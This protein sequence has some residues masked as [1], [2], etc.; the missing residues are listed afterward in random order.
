MKKLVGNTLLAATTAGAL[1]M[2]ACSAETQP[3]RAALTTQALEKAYDSCTVKE[4]TN[5][6]QTR[7][8]SGF[9]LQGIVDVTVDAPRSAAVAADHNI[10]IFYSEP[11]DELAKIPGTGGSIAWNEPQDAPSKSHIQVFP[12]L[13]TMQYPSLGGHEDLDIFV[14]AHTVE[15]DGTPSRESLRFCGEIAINATAQAVTNA[16]I[17]PPIH[18]VP[19]VQI[20]QI[21]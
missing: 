17:E 14:K 20:K 3:D 16:S 7:N 11:T 21:S 1:F 18:A 10:T 5:P 6:H 13:H 9:G 19:A 15:T 8:N 4:V 2:G 12:N